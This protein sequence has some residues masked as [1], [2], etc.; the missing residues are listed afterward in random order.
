MRQRL[1]IGDEFMLTTEEWGAL[2]FLCAVFLVIL[3]FIF[4]LAWDELC[5]RREREISG[6]DCR[7][8]DLRDRESGDRR[9]G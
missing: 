4:M 2:V 8:R 3:V 9:R 6:L 1:L 7:V 5:W